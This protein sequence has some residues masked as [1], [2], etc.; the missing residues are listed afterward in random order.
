VYDGSHDLLAAL[1]ATPT[2]LTSLVRDCS[3]EQARTARGGDEDWSVVEVVCH[4]RD[5]EAEAL[6]RMHAMRDEME[7]PLAA[8]DQEQWA[9]ERRYREDHL[10]AALDA[11]CAL[12]AQ[13]VGELSHLS[14]EQWDRAGGH[15]EY[16]RVTISSHTLHIVSH[17]CIHLAQIGSQLTT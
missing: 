3:E 1:R 6:A 12:R 16:G 11:F 8:Y 15:E 4:L 14:A 13:H 7:P 2:I 17:D 10:R 5:A 9:A